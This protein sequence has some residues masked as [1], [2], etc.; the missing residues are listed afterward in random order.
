MIWRIEWGFVAERDLLRLPMR[1]AER[2]DAAIIVF[3]RTGRGSVKR[4][5]P[6]DPRRLKLTI[7]GAVALMYADEY[8]GVLTVGRVFGRSL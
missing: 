7:P 6:T 3:A 1:T 5:V 8:D 4:V 2:L